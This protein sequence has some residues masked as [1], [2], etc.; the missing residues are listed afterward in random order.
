MNPE[1]KTNKNI[2]S[3]NKRLKNLI[4]ESSMK[5]PANNPIPNF[6]YE[7]KLTDEKPVKDKPYYAI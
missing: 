1:E 3:I 7:I 6:T 2:S 4:D 5:E